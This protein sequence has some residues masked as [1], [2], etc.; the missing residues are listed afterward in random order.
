MDRAAPLQRQQGDDAR[1]AACQLD[2]GR[3][4][5]DRQPG[6]RCQLAVPPGG[7]VPVSTVIAMNRR[8]RVLLSVVMGLAMGC[9]ESG[10]PPAASNSSRAT[11]EEARAIAKEKLHVW[12]YALVDDHRVRSPLLHRP[13][14]SRVQSAVE[15]IGHNTRLYTPADTTIQTINSDT[16]YSFIGVDV[17][18]EPIVITVSQV[19]EARYYGISI[20]DLWGHCEMLGTRTTGNGA[21]SFLIAGPGWKGETPPRDQE[22]HSHGDHPGIGRVSNPA[23]QNPGAN[24]LA[25]VKSWTTGRK[26]NES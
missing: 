3:R 24:I 1:Q 11:P 12:G 6:R 4:S 7:D 2:A 22:G 8:D 15:Q 23:L 13:H 18:D 25:D 19:E 21:A 14:E 26:G 10:R 9:A 17:R 20:F 16:L 5:E